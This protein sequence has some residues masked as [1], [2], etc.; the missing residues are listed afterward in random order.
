MSNTMRSLDSWVQYLSENEIP[1]LRQTVRSMAAAR[2]NIDMVNG[3]EIS[4]LVLNDPMMTLRVFAYIRPFHGKRVL[5]EITTVAHAT[6]MLGVEPFFR[7][8]EHLTEIE[9]VL[10][11]HPQAMLRLLQVIRRAQRAARY[12]YIWATW[13]VDLNIEEVTVAALLHDTAEIMMLC[14]APQQAMQIYALQQ[15]DH[16]MRSATAQERILGFPLR[17]L[18]QALCKH[19]QLPELLLNLID[20]GKADIPRVKNVKLAADL[21]R[22]SANG[23]DDPALPDDYT[24][25][26]ALLNISH[27]DLM[28]KLGL[29]QEASK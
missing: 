28:N 22:H 17:D 23:W 10:K 5:Q 27:E 6:M 24:A 9:N 20:D 19:W 11:P 16:H 18:Q 1:V 26:E 2:A 21:A 3:R 15:A 29:Q 4:S 14:F 7:H 13:R 12:A 25:I 8:F